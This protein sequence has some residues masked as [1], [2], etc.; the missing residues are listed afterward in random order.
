M[1]HTCAVKSVMMLQAKECSSDRKTLPKILYINYII[2]YVYLWRASLMFLNL[3]SEETRFWSLDM[4]CFVCFVSLSQVL[5][6]LYIELFTKAAH[7]CNTPLKLWVHASISAIAAHFSIHVTRSCI[8][9]FD[10]ISVTTSWLTCNYNRFVIRKSGKQIVKVV[11]GG[12]LNDATIKLM[13][14]CQNVI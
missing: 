11:E 3:P 2:V 5:L 1:A 14:V 13:Y 6:S 8:F 9:C 4:I 7:I 10:M 12:Q